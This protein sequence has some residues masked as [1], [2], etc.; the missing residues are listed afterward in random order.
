MILRRCALIPILAAGLW[1]I[2]GAALPRPLIFP[3]PRQIELGAGDFSLNAGVTI[4]LP[5]APS[6]T[7]LTLARSLAAEMG[8]RYG[9]ALASRSFDNLPSGQRVI[10]M[11]EFT[12][13]LIARY[14][15]Q[16]GLKVTAADPGPEGYILRVD[17][18]VV[19]IAGS[20]AAGAFYGQQSLRQM[21]TPSE[22]GCRIPDA[23]I[24]DWPQKSF[25][26][27][28][29]YLPGQNSLAFFHHLIRDF[30]ALYKFNRVIIE[31]NGCMR[32]DSHPEVNAGWAD[33]ARD[34]DYARRN[35]PPGPFHE[36]EQNSSHQDDADGG[37]LEKS[38]VAEMVEFC[39]ENHLEVIPEIPSM[40]HCFYLLTRHRELALDPQDKWPEAYCPAN[41]ASYRLLFDVIDEYIDVMKPK[42]MHMG[43]DEYFTPIGLNP[44]CAGEDPLVMYAQDIRRIHD[45]LAAKGVRMAIWGDY[46]LTGV[47]G[48]GPLKKKAPD[49]WEYLAP[50]AL[51]A[52]QVRDLVPKD[53]LIFNWMWSRGDFLDH[54]A[55]YDQFGFQ[56]I[57]GNFA[58]PIAN[59]EERS[60]RASILGG[61]PSA[62]AATTDFNFR[63]DMMNDCFAAAS[64][65][66]SGR[67]LQGAKLADVV[68]ASVPELQRDFDP[69]PPPSA[70]DP[71][72]PL[73]I[74]GAFNLPRTGAAFGVELGEI[75]GAALR[76]QAGGF[77]LT[78]AAAAGKAAAVAVGTEGQDP[79]PLS[80]VSAAIPIGRDVTSL[81]FLQACA[82]PAT[83]K[84]AYR[85]IWDPA[86]SAD[87]LG[88][89]EIVYQDGYVETVP[90]RY[91]VNILEWNWERRPDR[92]GYCYDADLVESGKPGA[93]PLSF[94]AFEWTNPRLGQVI[95]EVRLK[96][97]R[98]FH[99]APAGYTNAFG[100]V[101]PSN[102]VVLAAVS[103]VPARGSR[104]AP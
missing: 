52:E 96:G 81:V 79:N 18:D 83:N 33:F 39:R 65:L 82:R 61:A 17:G 56:Q 27:I 73:D 63:K 32:L 58:S 62:W 40:T 55:Q 11:G 21:V 86:D 46:L 74:S 99:G 64:M 90:I 54:E 76:R 9:V 26:G 93:A 97:T 36:R 38:Q 41:P 1:P 80:P 85:L 20:D 53:I 103:A 44:Q 15:R 13:P 7:D 68:Q 28:K 47:W 67:S 3:T 87:L 24:R 70:T 31:M 6:D 71:L 72:V 16:H 35:Y 95:R 37:L 10:L 8:D 23:T 48:A 34:T 14:C 104:G 78:G 98:G 4:A 19:L 66:W 75:A 69:V 60:R 91:G 88:W 84:E 92:A 49:G 59:Y 43:H 29:F 22:G 50:G 100:P 89:Y 25:R 57:Y 2:R 102:A 30:A 5:A 51:S 77:V 42:M 45:H 101:I 94:F 12:N